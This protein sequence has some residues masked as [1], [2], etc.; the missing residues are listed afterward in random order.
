MDPEQPIYAIATADERFAFV[1]TP[2]R[3]ATLMIAM[4]AGFALLLAVAGVYSVVSYGVN[5]RTQEMGLRMTLGASRANLRLLIVRQALLPVAIGA[6][7]GLAGAIAIGR[8]MSG[9][10]FG[11]GAT[12]PLT[13]GGVVLTLV[14]SA[15]LASYLPARRASAVDPATALRV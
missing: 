1:A 15:A 13:F 11:V 2:R 12:D 8:V 4:F 6:A 9:L 7:V 5:Q 14:G 10:L 3:I